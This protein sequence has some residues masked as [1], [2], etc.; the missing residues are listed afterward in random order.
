MIDKQHFGK[1]VA[2]AR[3]R[4]GISQ[5]ELAERLCVTGQAV[6]KWECGSALPDVELL[7]A[8][9][10]IFGVT[11]NELLEDADPITAMKLGEEFSGGIHYFR[12]HEGID[13]GIRAF[14]ESVRREGW[15][16][17][18]WKRAQEAAEHPFLPIGRR[19]AAEGGLILEIGAGPGG[20]FMPF[21][22]RAAPNAHIIISDLCPGVVEEWKR[23]LDAKLG[24]PELAFAVCDF[25]E[26]PFPDESFSVVADCGGVANCIGDRQR[27]LSE[28]HRVLKPDGVYVTYNGFVTRD[29]LDTIPAPARERLRSEYP[30]AFDDLYEDTVLAG[31]NRIDSEMTASWDTDGDESGFASLCRELGVNLRVC[32]YVRYCRKK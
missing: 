24:S 14:S 10:H 18:N 21:V 6:S 9:S 17:I 27:A 32:G 30:N 13:D 25:T 4:L 20:G 12:S 5:T 28:I 29:T 1:R 16:P 22:L 19:I 23:L 26:L 8:L 2:S 3:R 11:I 15:I 7:L 31:F